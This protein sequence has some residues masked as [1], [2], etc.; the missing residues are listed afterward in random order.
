MR[1]GLVGVVV[2]CFVTASALTVMTAP[3]DAQPFTIVLARDMGTNVGFAGDPAGWWNHDGGTVAL[4]GTVVGRFVRSVRFT[5]G[6]NAPHDVGILTIAVYLLGGDPPENCTGQGVH[7][8]ATGAESGGISACSAG[9]A[10]EV[11]R[12]FSSADGVTFT[13]H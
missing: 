4:N 6:S 2:V 5:A 3:A 10:G 1:K 12:A 11:G 9:L 8:L 13:I 7:N